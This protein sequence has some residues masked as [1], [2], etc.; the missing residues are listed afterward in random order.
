MTELLQLRIGQQTA[1]KNCQFTD[2]AFQL[3][4]ILAEHLRIFFQIFLGQD[5]SKV[6]I[7]DKAGDGG[8][9]QNQRAQRGS[10]LYRKSGRKQRYKPVLD[11]F[12]L[13]TYGSF[14]TSLG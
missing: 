11:V 6:L 10:Q 5:V 13:H 4:G 1:G 2:E 12:T 14:N 7:S 3:L 8:H 9:H